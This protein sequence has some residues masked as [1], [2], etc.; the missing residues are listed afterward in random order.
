MPNFFLTLKQ[1]LDTMQEKD[2]KTTQAKNR[3]RRAGSAAKLSAIVKPPRMS[4]TEWQVALRKQM[5]L[6]ETY[7]IQENDE[8][9][10]GPRSH[11]AVAGGDGTISGCHRPYRREGR[12]GLADTRGRQAGGEVGARDAWKIVWMMAG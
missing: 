10:L 1:Q 3:K 4:L 6:H 5:A 9:S 8:D 7:A 11:L 12:N 2:S